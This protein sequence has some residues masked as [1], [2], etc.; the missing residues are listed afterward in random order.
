MS[1]RVID[2]S[3]VRD[4]LSNRSPRDVLLA[5][6]ALQLTA[7]GIPSLGAVQ[8]ADEPA[9]GTTIDA[10]KPQTAAQQLP[11]L[12]PTVT[13]S[14]TPPA[15]PVQVAAVALAPPPEDIGRYLLDAGDKVKIR[16]YQ[17]E[18][19]SGDYLVDNRGA[20]TLPVLGSFKAAGR[21]EEQLRA[22]ISQAAQ[23]SMVHNTD[24]VVDVAERRPI[25]IVGFVDRPGVYPFA[26]RMTVVHAISMA[27]GPYR[28][29][30]GTGDTELATI[31][32][33]VQDDTEKL[34]LVTVRLARLESERDQ[35]PF[36]DMPSDLV[37][38]AGELEARDL[39][40]RE[41]RL[42]ASEGEVRAQLLETNKSAREHAKAELDDLRLKVQQID[43]QL[44]LNQTQK[45]ALKTLIAKGFVRTTQVAAIDTTDATFSINRLE[46]LASISRAT[47]TLEELSSDSKAKEL[48]R[49]RELAN[50][51]GAM[52]HQK[53]A[54]KASLGS[55]RSA[56]GLTKGQDPYRAS[57]AGQEQLVYSVLRRSA[58]GLVSLPVDDI[59][60]LFPGDVLKVAATRLEDTKPIVTGSN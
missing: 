33:R 38:L 39:L 28:P 13:T 1:I 54:L 50:E 22:D 35:R 16:I 29:K 2:M 20:V 6:L 5:L 44:K 43:N 17:R 10:S 11:A 15:M 8:A 31:L 12:K 47:R 41:Q 32:N 9:H 30:S 14:G 40:S 7:I 26:L 21:D 58:K 57:T 56:A 24:V 37:D 52:A 53:E 18:D 19:L 51:I 49:K 4:W 46:A 42:Q 27:G 3:M 59:T 45:T 55:E 23:K 36:T 48:A 60:P 25:Y 34:K